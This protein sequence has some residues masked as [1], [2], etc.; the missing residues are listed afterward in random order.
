MRLV[1][2]N[3]GLPRPVMWRGKTIQTAI[4]KSPVSGAVPVTSTNLEGDRQADPSVHGAPDMTVYAY[5]SEH[6]AFWR[7][8]LPGM[9][10]PWGAFGE[11]FSTEGLLED[12]ARI[13]DRLSIGSAQ[14]AVTQPRMPCFKLGI[15][16]GRQDIVKRFMKSGR[17]GFYLTVL[18]EGEVT[19]GDAIERFAIG[20][21]SLTV[22]DIVSL[23]EDHT[24][25]PA[26][27][28]RATQ[29][30]SLPESWREHFRK[31]ENEAGS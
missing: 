27:L 23:A 25:N 11:N 28:R 19:A 1:S 6:Y 5:P 24:A 31:L 13:G 10:L 3:V 18:H 20:E 15:R 9:D 30:A 21:P 17:T 8:E 4:W 29:L 12:N 14:F 16:F 26:L 2:V 22:S 7:E